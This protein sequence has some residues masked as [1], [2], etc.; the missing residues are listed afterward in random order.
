MRRDEENQNILKKI[1]DLHKCTEQLCKEI[2][3][4]QTK[5][6][7]LEEVLYKGNSEQKSVKEEIAT[8]ESNI[9]HQQIRNNKNEEVI[10]KLFWAITIGVS[11][12]FLMT[13]LQLYVNVSNESSSKNTVQVVTTANLTNS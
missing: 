7:N 4:L 1:S 5:I 11:G 10:Q 13:I 2:S 3:T 6:N 12:T 8:L 9:A